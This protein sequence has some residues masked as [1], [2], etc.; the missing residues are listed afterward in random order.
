MRSPTMGQLS[1]FY[2]IVAVLTVLAG[3][4][5]RSQSQDQ[6]MSGT[7]RR[8]EWQQGQSAPSLGGQ[9]DFG[10]RMMEQHARQM[11]EMQRDMED[12]RRL[13]EENRNRAIQQAVRASEEQWRRIKPKLDHIERLKA[14]AEVSAGPNSGGGSGN[15][16]GQGFMFG[17]M[18]AGGSGGVFGA[19]GGMGPTGSPG[20]QGDTWSQTWTMGPKNP[21]EMTPGET[22]CQELNHLLQGE[23]V[24]AFAIAEKVA[25]LRQIRAKAREDLARARQELRT[26]IHPNQEPALVVMGYLD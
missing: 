20:T 4:V 12:M 8:S 5:G 17:G 21:M 3:A 14:E 19:A 15:F 16:Q 25:A 18:S 11:Q 26:M 22:V 7:Q 13:A 9:P 1:R 2:A 10:Q 23:S 6:G 24:S